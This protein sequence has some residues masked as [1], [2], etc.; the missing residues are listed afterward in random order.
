[1]E[2]RAEQGIGRG[3]DRGRHL[4]HAGRRHH[5]HPGLPHRPLPAG[6]ASVRGGHVRQPGQ[7]QQVEDRGE[8][9]DHA[10]VAAAEP[11]RLDEQNDRGDQ[12]GEHEHDQPD[13]GDLGAQ[14]GD[15][16]GDLGHRRMQR[17]DA[18]AAVEDGP[19]EVDDGAVMEDPV[20]LDQA[21]RGIGGK[22]GDRARGQDLDGPGP[23]HPR[24]EHPGQQGQHEHVAERVGDRDALLQP[25]Q[26]GGVHVRGDQVDPRQQGQPHGQRQRVDHAAPVPVGRAPPDEDQQRGRVQRVGQQV[27]DVGVGGE[28]ERGLHQLG[29]QEAHLAGDEARLR[30]GQQQPGQLARGTVDDH[31][32]DDA[33]HA[34]QADQAPRLNPQ[35]GQRVIRPDEQ[36]PPDGIAAQDISSHLHRNPPMPVHSC[37]D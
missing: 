9:R 19:A 33:A 34:G 20:Q 11:E 27:Q 14:P 21:V 5:G 7:H 35:A 36:R 23:S 8:H 10:Q 25:G 31:A 26:P 29:H 12:R 32:R 3:L 15:R 17:R 16:L 18:P 6:R 37:P 2:H 28:R 1:M 13:P 4:V 22:H 30:G 24:R